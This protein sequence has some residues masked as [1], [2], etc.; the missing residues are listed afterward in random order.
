MMTA[1]M[2]IS[3]CDFSSSAMAPNR[4]SASSVPGKWRVWRPSAISQAATTAKQ[5]LRNS[6]GCSEKPGSAIQRRAPLIS[7]PMTSVAAVSTS[8]M[9]QPASATR[10]TPRGDS[11]LTPT[12]ISPATAR[13]KNCLRMKISRA[14]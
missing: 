6:L 12:T 13:K 8:A 1:S 2:P 14:W 4:P 11:R 10:R 7:V 5:G 9:T 3:G